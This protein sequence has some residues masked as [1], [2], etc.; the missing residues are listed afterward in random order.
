MTPN[1]KIRVQRK[2]TKRI[3]LL[4]LLNSIRKDIRDY[5]KKE[6]K[7]RNVTNH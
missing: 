1:I 5:S 6:N 7:T 2:I 3:K 4:F